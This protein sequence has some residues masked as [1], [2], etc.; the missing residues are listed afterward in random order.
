VPGVIVAKHS[1]SARLQHWP[2]LRRYSPG[3]HVAPP[4]CHVAAP[5]APPEPEGPPV[6]VVALLRE[7]ASFALKAPHSAE[8][9][10]EKGW[11]RRGGG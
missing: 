11:G 1:H 6:P 4:G 2:G 8:K 7:D 3:C 5:E 9:S 10:V